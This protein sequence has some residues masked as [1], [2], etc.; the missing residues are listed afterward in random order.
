MNN[1]LTKHHLL[2]YCARSCACIL[3]HHEGYSTG[4]PPGKY[5]YHLQLLTTPLPA[6]PA[7]TSWVFACVNKADAVGSVLQGSIINYLLH[8]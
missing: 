6:S 5:P 7:F 1:V 4:G 8:L 3:V 2:P